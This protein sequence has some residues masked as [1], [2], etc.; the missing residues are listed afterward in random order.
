MNF[1]RFL[2]CFAL[3]VFL[4][5]TFTDDAY[6]TH[7]WLLISFVTSI[8]ILVWFWLWPPIDRWLFTDRPYTN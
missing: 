4:L 1:R 5:A 6:L 7:P 3:N 2:I 8:D